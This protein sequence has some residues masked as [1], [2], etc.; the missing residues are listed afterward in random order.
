MRIVP[1]LLNF[2]CTIIENQVCEGEGEQM[3]RQRE[4]TPRLAPLSR[5]AAVAGEYLQVAFIVTAAR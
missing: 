4:A 3:K 1:T 5:C 2:C